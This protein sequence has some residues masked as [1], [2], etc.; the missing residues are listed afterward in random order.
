MQGHARIRGESDE[1][2]LGQRRVEGAHHDGRHLRVP[3]QRAAPGNVHGRLNQRLVHGKRDVAIAPDAALVAQGLRE[4]LAHYDAHVLHRVVTVDL[5][6][7]RGA[8]RQVE[9]AVAPEGGEHVVEKADAGLHV[10][11]AGAVQVKRQLDVGF[12][13]RARKACDAFAHVQAPFRKTAG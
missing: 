2:F 13:R 11:G 4:R 3:I 6:V 7:A 12:V 8:D 9:Q 1:E 10:G 5:Q